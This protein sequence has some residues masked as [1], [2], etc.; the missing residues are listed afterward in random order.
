[1]SNSKRKALMDT[2]RGPVGKSAV[3][4]AKDRDSNQVA[5]RVVESTDAETLQGF[6]AEH[7][8][9]GAQ[10]YTDDAKA[11]QGMPFDHEAVKH[12]VGEYVREIAHT[13]GMESFWAMLKR[14]Y[15][16]IN[17][18]MSPK[19]LHRYVCEFSGRHNVRDANTINQMSVVVSN[20]VGKRLT[21]AQLV[22]KNGLDSGARS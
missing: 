1:M 18:K 14:G 9:P 10:V 7:A 13:N 5:A 6:V 2:G 15:I 17:H 12:S 3:V 20:M 8:E 16:G 21:F 22:A 19:H 11:Y 4:G